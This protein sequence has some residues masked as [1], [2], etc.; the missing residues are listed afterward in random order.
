MDD[1]SLKALAETLRAPARA[2]VTFT[3][4]YQAVVATAFIPWDAAA[5]ALPPGLELRKFA[6]APDGMHPLILTFGAQSNVTTKLADVPIVLNYRESAFLIPN[7]G[8]TGDARNRAAIFMPRLDVDNLEAAAMGS[9]V[10]YD[11]K[12]SLI[13]T[14]AKGFHVRALVTGQELYTLQSG[15]E[16]YVGKPS[17]FPNF[18]VTVGMLQQPILSVSAIGERI[19]TVMTWQFSSAR[20]NGAQ[21]RLTVSH[22]GMP[23]LPA[24]VYNWA[25]YGRTI[26]GSGQLSV[27][28]VLQGPFFDWPG[29]ADALPV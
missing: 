27:S 11:K 6:G 2:L 7:T 3:G 13:D 26:T 8:V 1:A 29:S 15:S 10:G 24:G 22:D 4:N 12:L 16:G 23:A 5:A 21:S 20:L 14:G 25:E 9:C 19:F 17:D 18:A 28:W